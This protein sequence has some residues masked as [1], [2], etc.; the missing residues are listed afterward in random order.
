[1]VDTFRYDAFISY[2]HRQPDKMW[3]DW[4]VRALE[5]YAPPRS[6]RKSLGAQGKPSRVTRVFRDEDE[7]STGG[8]LSQQLKEALDQSRA[9]IVVCSRNTPASP[10]VNQEV[11]YFESLGRSAHVMPLLVE[12]EPSEAFPPTLLERSNAD[13]RIAAPAGA[14]ARD[15]EPLAADVRPTAGRAARDVKRRALLKLVAGILG[16]RYDDLYQRDLRRR[17]RRIWSVAALVGIC[18]AGLLSWFTWT[19]TD[20]YQINA[21]LRDGPPLIVDA[22]G[23]DA[24]AWAQALAHTGRPDDALRAAE[25][26]T[27]F[28]GEQVKVLLSLA[29]VLAQ[30]GDAARAQQV[31]EMAISG[32]SGFRPRLRAELSDYAAERLFARGMRD[33]ALRQADLALEDTSAIT[34]AAER[35]AAVE[36]LARRI[37]E[38]RGAEEASHSNEQD[39]TTA[40]IFAIEAARASKRGGR[41]DQAQRL[42]LTGIEHTSGI[43]PASLRAYVELYLANAAA[44]EGIPL[45]VDYVNRAVAA[46]VKVPTAVGRSQTTRIAVEAL[47][48]AGNLDAARPLLPEISMQEDRDAAVETLIA[49][50]A[51]AGRADDVGSLLEDSAGRSDLDIYI[52]LSAAAEAAADGDQTAMLALL[53]RYASTEEQVEMR[54]IVAERQRA[55]GRDNREA[56]TLAMRAALDTESEI[57]TSEQRS[58]IVGELVATGRVAEAK[59]VAATMTD[60]HSQAFA[61]IAIA[62]EALARHANDEVGTLLAEAE[63]AERR[64]PD[65][66]LVAH[67]LNQIGI[68]LGSAGQDARARA[69]LDESIELAASQGELGS[70][71]VAD[72]LVELA[73]QGERRTARVT[74]NQRCTASDRLRVYAAI[75]SPLAHGLDE[76]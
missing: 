39:A 21:V 66:D 68:L 19:R 74:A 56:L 28:G 25:A 17:Q 16:V 45:P 9:L 31:T 22:G 27:T 42:A 32:I 76:N 58:R 63:S 35:V 48:H 51:R 54:V 41:A 1:M 3:A 44:V 53:D 62:R 7:T 15:V 70:S 30:Q 57:D 67:G 75:L 59:T 73:R 38:W 33:Q 64:E 12:G 34:D 61:V 71:T 36:V 11:D 18:T 8:D 40:A 52:V 4:L 60:A 13:A 23:D 72:A 49:G 65:P 55:M 43:E 69:L 37:V 29:D 50:Y 26:T 46:A 5:T 14:Q 2:R 47:V 20:T 10:W 6:L 24:A